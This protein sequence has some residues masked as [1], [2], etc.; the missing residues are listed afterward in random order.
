[1]KFTTKI[2]ACVIFFA[3]F[4]IFSHNFAVT[5]VAAENDRVSM[6]LTTAHGSFLYENRAVTLNLNG[7]ILPE[8][9]MPPILLD[10]RTF[11][12]VRHV[13]EALGAIVDFHEEQQRI[14]IAY[15]DSLIVMH[16]GQYHFNFDDRLLEMDVVPQ[17]IN[18]RTMVPVSFIASALGFGVYW[19]CETATVY[20]TSPTEP[21]PEYSNDNH[22][23]Y[24]NHHHYEDEQDDAPIALDP[25]VVNFTALS[26]DVTPAPI[27]PETNLETS[28][29]HVSWNES[30]T[31]FAITAAGRI[32]WADWHMLEDG[33]LVVDIHHA[34][35]D[36]A[37]S[38]F[39]INN[40]FIS[41]IRTGQQIFDGVNVARVVFDLTVPVTFS[42]SISP[43]RHHIFV[44][45]E[46][47]TITHIN[48][49]STFDALGRE[50]IAITGQ[51]AP[52]AD[53]FVLFNPLRLVIDVPNAV[54]G[55]YSQINIYG[56]G[57]FVE[58]VR[59]SQF[60]ES[61]V[62][63]VADLTRHPAFSVQ[64]LGNTATIHITEPTF[65]NVYYNA[66]TGT[67]EIV[68]PEGL[69]TNQILR[70]ERYLERKYLFVLPGDFSDHFGYGEFVLR[71]NSLRSVEIATEN[72]MTTL[73]FNTTQ[74]MAYEL[75][76]NDTNIY[77]RPIHPRHR[78]PFI[79]VIDPGHGG[80]APGAVHH[81]MRESDLNLDTARMV[82]EML[83]ADGIVR[84]YMTRHTDVNVTN[85]ARAEM[86][87]QVA[88][89]FVSIHYNAANSR[90]HGTETLYFV[91]EHEN[92]HGFNSR[93]L[94][95]ILQDNLIA[96]LGS[97]DRGLRNR[98]LLIV[99]NQTRIPAALVEVGFMD[100]PA[101]AALIAD[102]AYRRRAAE[103]IVRGIYEAMEAFG[104][105]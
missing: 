7:E 103:A 99:L 97:V 89:I 18:A 51:T 100:N 5:A 74:I 45:F 60:N 64:L 93:Q 1:M 83:Q 36:F 29:H 50:T 52:A 102:P 79:V 78:Y 101:E 95:Q 22:D 81:G 80:T 48:F 33:R 27:E 3:I 76:E 96:E 46:K 56:A 57:H 38:N 68:R 10:S 37:Q 17:I 69:G 75:W 65:R 61:T 62:R 24:E 23:N 67:I 20:L 6:M 14:M 70:F 71:H 77:I 25:G 30:Q 90:A 31:Q 12:P 47:N 105:R 42:V 63:I 66:E 85:S 21:N 4:V 13:M 86:A 104:P 87:N 91:T 44:T 15:H 58:G 55:E 28:L 73:T 98:P 35:T 43:D 16:I 11:V 54:L 49:E 8:A 32:S 26:R 59:Y 88:D 34:V 53:V 9:D 40:S 84:V 19:H 41:T 39:T 2:F 82:M 92:P 72:G 94:A